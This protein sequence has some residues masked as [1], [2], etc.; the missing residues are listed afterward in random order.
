MDVWV[1]ITQ[2]GRQKV[3]LG[4]WRNKLLKRFPRASKDGLVPLDNERPYVVN[5]KNF[6]REFYRPRKFLGLSERQDVYQYWLENEPDAITFSKVLTPG[7]IGI[8]GDTIKQYSNSEHLRRLV[9]P[10]SSYLLI[11]AIAGLAALAAGGKGATF[12]GRR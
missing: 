9:Q 1:V 7:S 2:D 4:T 5:P 11:L 12:G 6:V 3:W 10:E 8:T